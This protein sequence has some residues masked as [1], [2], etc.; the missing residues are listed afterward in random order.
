MWEIEYWGFSI[1]YW[2]F[3]YLYWVMKIDLF[4]L[5]VT[6][7]FRRCVYID[8]LL[9]IYDLIQSKKGEG[10]QFRMTACFILNVK[11]FLGSGQGST[12]EL[13]KGHM[14]DFAPID[15]AGIP[16][17][18]KEIWSREKFRN[19]MA[20]FQKMSFVVYFLI[21]TCFA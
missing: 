4:S 18:Q 5:I 14:M 11:A 20:F 8:W 7:K 1:K 10:L 12:C 15:Q 21:R 13:T 3:I 2:R 17:F 9:I 6:F 19:L 16:I